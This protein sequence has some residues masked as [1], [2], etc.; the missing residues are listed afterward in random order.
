MSDAVHEPMPDS[1]LKKYRRVGILLLIV[2]A[3][4]VV[5]GVLYVKTSQRQSAIIDTARENLLWSAMQLERESMR[6]SLFLKG[7][8]NPL[9]DS[10]RDEAVLRFDLLYSRYNIIS[11]GDM[12]AMLNE[13]PRLLTDLFL[14][15]ARLDDIDEYLIPWSE[16]ESG[17]RADIDA[18]TEQLLEISNRFINAIMAFR[19]EQIADNRDQMLDLLR[20]LTFAI[21]VLVASTIVVI[22]LLIRSVLAER[23]QFL[24]A[25][26]L[27]RK[28]QASARQAEA[29]SQAKSEFLAM[30]SHEI[31][32]PLNGILGMLNLLA[33]A[34]L[35]RTHRDYASAARDS[36][37]GLLVIVNDILDMSSVEAGQLRLYFETVMLNSFVADIRHHAE[38]VIGTKPIKLEIS[39]A[40]ALPAR[41][42]T[43]GGR[44]RQVV[45][46]LVSNAAK[47]T[48]KGSLNIQLGVSPNPSSLPGWDST[49]HEVGLRVEV[50]D[51]G[52]GIKAA[53]RS[54]LFQGFSQIDSASNRKFGGTGLGLSIC[55]RLVE[56]LGGRIDFSSEYG[57]GSTFW[58]DTPVSKAAS[59]KAAESEAVQFSNA[60]DRAEQRTL[61]VEDGVIA[62]IGFSEADRQ[63]IASSLN[64]SPA[65]LRWFSSSSALAT[66]GLEK[67]GALLVHLDSEEGLVW[68][69][70]NQ[71]LTDRPGLPVIAVV[72]VGARELAYPFIRMGGKGVLSY[73]L[74]PQALRTRIDSLL[75]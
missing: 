29:A 53:D 43:D 68:A 26:S 21:S 34:P 52:L 48:D 74:D 33:E 69:L 16:G 28:L 6:W 51:T 7:S 10:M 13:D 4:L 30:M 49:L 24:I 60:T 27:G 71:V 63:L 55:K 54:K 9:P 42:V 58:F 1:I 56:M 11:Q 41:F 50:R 19:T 17:Y 38:S 46:N 37:D 20:L 12:R 25:R 47:F 36:A 57:A 3:A 45:L 40:P 72:G 44:L 2:A 8:K 31:R 65:R 35:S 15:K 5:T 59:D 23:K 62:V 66:E 22:G 39:V 32:T 61:S 75:D 73:P 70:L 18:L 64:N 67:A 14:F